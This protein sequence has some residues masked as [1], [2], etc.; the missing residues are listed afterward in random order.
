M[1]LPA[2]T[3][4]GS[5][6]IVAP[7][8][9]GG[10]GEVYRARDARLNREV[11]IKVLP[12][13]FAADRER[14]ARFEREAQTLAALNHQNIAHVHGV[15]DEPAALV[16]ELVEGEDLS[17][18]LSRG[19]IPLDEA[20]PIARQIADALEAAHER[21]I[22]HRDLKPANIKLRA[23]GVVKVLDF[24]LAKALDPAEISNSELRNSPTLTSPATMMGMILG[25]AAYMA[26]EQAK[27]RAVDRRAD[28]WAFG[29]VLYEMLTGRRAFEGGD[30]SEVLASVI[31]D[32][33]SAEALPAGTPIAIRRLIRRC[34]EKDRAKRLDSMAAARLEIDEALSG[35]GESVSAAASQRPPGRRSLAAM[36]GA[37]L[38]LLA[39]GAALAWTLKPEPVV[40][41]PVARF[42][43]TLPD[44]QPFGSYS[45]P[46]LDISPDGRRVVYRT[47][48][49]IHVRDLHEEE[50]RELTRAPG[51]GIWMSPDGETV[52]FRTPSGLSRVPVTGGAVRDLIAVADF[53]GAHWHHDGAI[54]Y[55]TPKAI[56]RVPDQGGS[57][58][59]LIQATKSQSLGW[60]QLLPGNR[61]LYSMWETE[62][63][64]PVT[65]MSALDGTNA[66]V[67]MKAAHARYL[68]S[69]HLL[70]GREG[71]AY[72]VAFDLAREE[73]SGTPVAVPETVHVNQS[74]GWL[75]ISVA[76]TG[77]AAYV[78]NRASENRTRLVWAGGG[79]ISVALDSPRVYSDPRLTPDGRRVALHLWDQQNDIWVGDLV[80]GRLTRLTFTSE[81]EETP[82]WS[83]DGR[84]LAF[85]ADR[86]PG[87]R[88]V[89]RKAADGGAAAPEHVIWQTADH[90]HVTD[91]SPDGRTIIVE[92]RRAGT[93][94]DLLAID[95]ASGKERV[96]VASAFR[97]RQARLSSDG[98]W[99][100][101]TSDES[102]RDEVY[103]Q[104]FP[105]LQGRAMVSAAGGTEPVWSR[106]GRRLFFRGAAQML[107][108]SLTSTS[109][110]EFAP[111][112]TLFADT[113][114]RTQGETHTHFDVDA[115]GR[116]LM[117]DQGDLRTPRE[118]DQIHIVLNW[119]EQLKKLTR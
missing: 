8:G 12:Q 2:G 6:E 86:G 105:S 111:P 26:P 40:D 42:G 83:P 19:A 49:A 60:P 25:T 88:Q 28:V 63:S 43:V 52:L 18:R 101:Y 22:I 30:V 95:V 112:A 5:Y 118:R 45:L 64:E 98:K 33:P 10:M 61:L 35:G 56:W 65:M 36:A 119:A 46:I 117:I 81:E 51:S 69:G 91:W 50:P 75:Q 44:G 27:G 92:I 32:T 24:G 14:L 93:A 17:A 73:V 78:S 84:E 90:F 57:P 87:A 48:Q 109:P 80:R 55:S 37:V 107:S 41:R 9:A 74:S 70:Y 99:L 79:A 115:A 15:I 71:R 47:S 53:T 97:E 31:K 68:D 1:A 116:F 62:T 20:L 104:P 110:L 106:D 108:S 100:A 89:V 38:G 39:V 21:G 58:Q 13:T 34:L 11:A 7:L 72:A 85:A 102:G 3:R 4:I 113:F 66:R 16:M 59:A 103:V 94:N 114:T 82:V 29:V 96:L 77:T 76:R 54:I 67:V 23:D